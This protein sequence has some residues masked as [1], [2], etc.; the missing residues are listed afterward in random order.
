MLTAL[1]I[2]AAWVGARWSRAEITRLAYPLLAL[3]GIKLIAEDLRQGQ[4]LLLVLSLIFCGSG[5]IL[6][7]RLMRR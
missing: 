7:P 3:A 6:L 1:A 2:S 5:L 4:F